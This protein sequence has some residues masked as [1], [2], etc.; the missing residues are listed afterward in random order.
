MLCEC[1]CPFSTFEPA[2][3][4]LQNLAYT[5]FHCR[6]PD[7]YTLLF[8]I[9]SKNNMADARNYETYFALIL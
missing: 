8:P 4:F 1:V 9:V 3:R 2:S 7:H 6:G 5:L